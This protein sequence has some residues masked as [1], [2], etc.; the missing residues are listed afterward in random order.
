[1]VLHIA[2]EQSFDEINGINLIP[3]AFQMNRIKAH[4]PNKSVLARKKV[5]HVFLPFFLY[6]T[7]SLLRRY[8]F[9]YSVCVFFFESAPHTHTYNTHTHSI[10]QFTTCFVNGSNGFTRIGPNWIGWVNKSGF[11]HFLSLCCVVTHYIGKYC[12]H[13]LSPFSHRFPLYRHFHTRTYIYTYSKSTNALINGST[14]PK[15]FVSSR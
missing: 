5:T 10:Q 7:R 1:M 14:N 9:L 15:M 13:S 3:I 8:L 2:N 12:P 4:T 6:I 11:T